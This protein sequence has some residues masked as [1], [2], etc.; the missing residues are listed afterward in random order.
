MRY[1]SPFIVEEYEVARYGLIYKCYIFSNLSL[2]TAV[3]WNG[4]IVYFVNK[5]CKTRAI[6]AGRDSTTPDIWTV[7]KF[8]GCISEGSA[9][10]L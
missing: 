7:Y 1:T 3:M 9:L 5:L 8:Y 6:N 2:F 4:F 10:L